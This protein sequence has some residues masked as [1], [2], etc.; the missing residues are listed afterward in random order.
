MADVLKQQ[1]KILE[2][3]IGQNQQSIAPVEQPINP[4]QTDDLEFF[5]YTNPN[6]KI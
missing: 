6:I 2:N 3:I 1:N 4:I 5:L